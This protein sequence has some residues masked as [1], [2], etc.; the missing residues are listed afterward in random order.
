MPNVIA[1]GRAYV[2][3]IE[4]AQVIIGHTDVDEERERLEQ[5]VRDYQAGLRDLLSKVSAATAAEIL[6]ASEKVL[7]PVRDGGLN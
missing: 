3:L 1:L 4:A 5:L 2:R 6:A 7:G